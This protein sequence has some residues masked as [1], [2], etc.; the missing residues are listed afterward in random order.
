MRLTLFSDGIV[1]YF[2]PSY[3]C[4]KSDVISLVIS[5][6]YCSPGWWLIIVQFGILNY[7]CEIPG[8]SAWRN[9]M[10]KRHKWRSEGGWQDKNC[11]ASFISHSPLMH[12]TKITEFFV[13]VGNILELCTVILFR[14]VQVPPKCLCQPIYSYHCVETA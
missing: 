4:V 12:V 1:T 10:L 8:P 2:H 5:F 7:I 14:R 11:S 9:K 6:Q 13:R 3:D